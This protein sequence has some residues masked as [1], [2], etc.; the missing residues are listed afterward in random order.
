MVPERPERQS[1]LKLVR[2]ALREPGVLKRNFQGKERPLQKVA[3]VMGV[4]S[5]AL[6]NA[7]AS[8]RYG[9]AWE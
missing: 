8:L 3:V 9:G 2:L 6:R 5:A 7:G 1:S 4:A